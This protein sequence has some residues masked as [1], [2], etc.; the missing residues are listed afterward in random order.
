MEGR[1]VWC[2]QRD[3]DLIEVTVVARNRFASRP[4]ETVCLVHPE[5]EEAFRNHNDYAQRYGFLFLVCTGILVAAALFK[6][7]GAV[8][9]GAIVGALGALI[10]VFPF[11]TPETARVIGAK[12]SIQVARL[13]G[14]FLVGLGVLIGLGILR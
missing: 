4:R 2:H 8:G 13:L 7:W 9:Y 10:M 11:A 12:A 1:C 6:T 5:H 14:A 3:E